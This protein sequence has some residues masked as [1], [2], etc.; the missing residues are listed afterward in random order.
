MNPAYTQLAYHR[1][2]ITALRRLVEE[3]YLEGGGGVKEDLI[4]E[5]VP[6][7]IRQVPNES[8]IEVIQR[9]QE[10]EKTLTEEMAQYEFRK[11]EVR[12]IAKPDAS[13]VPAAVPRGSGGK[14]GKSRA[15]AAT[16][17]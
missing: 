17:R 5:A 4:C 16:S 9:L 7:E 11:R 6:Y 15:G 14:G 3:K 1:T 8:F 10:E 13:P 2:V 12:P